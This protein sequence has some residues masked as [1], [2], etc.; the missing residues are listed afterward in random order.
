MFSECGRQMIVLYSADP[1]K[2]CLSRPVSGQHVEV[3]VL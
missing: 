1:T 2:Y 3:V